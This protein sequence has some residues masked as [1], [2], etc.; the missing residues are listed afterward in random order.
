MWAFLL[1]AVVFILGKYTYD[2][3][4]QISHVIDEGGIY[5]K[6]YDLLQAIFTEYQAA[7]R[8]SPV[9]QLDSLTYR[10]EEPHG[11]THFTVTQLYG[12]VQIVWKY[13]NQFV[14]RNLEWCFPEYEN[15]LEIFSKV[16][17]DIGTN[18]IDIFNS[19]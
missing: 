10:F 4:Q 5:N 2:K 6:Y 15:Q 18:L 1:V 9:R 11:I 8:T 14:K 12:N 19:F 13:E 3:T 16:R 7:K 17:G